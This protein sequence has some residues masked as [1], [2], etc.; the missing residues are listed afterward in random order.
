MQGGSPAGSALRGDSSTPSEDTG[1]DERLVPADGARVSV[2][3]MST[4]STATD[5]PSTIALLGVITLTLVAL[6]AWTDLHAVAA[7]GIAVAAGIVAAAITRAI[8]MRR[9]RAAARGVS[10]S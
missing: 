8:V 2:V 1:S 10:G 5:A 9:R 6:G 7:V 4:R 3:G